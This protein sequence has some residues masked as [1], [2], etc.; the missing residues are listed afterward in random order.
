MPTGRHHSL[1]LAR[2]IAS[3]RRVDQHGARTANREVRA[4]AVLQ[5]GDFGDRWNSCNREGDIPHDGQRY[6]PRTAISERGLHRIVPGI[7]ARAGAVVSDARPTA[8][9]AVAPG[10]LIGGRGLDP[11]GQRV[12]DVESERSRVRRRCEDRQV[13]DGI[14]RRRNRDLRLHHILEMSLEDPHD[15]GTNIAEGYWITS[16]GDAN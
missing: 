5:R 6:A 10:P 11:P 12:G 1:S 4:T 9:L 14:D 16:Y 8:S 7:A 15:L 2:R 3:V 13:H